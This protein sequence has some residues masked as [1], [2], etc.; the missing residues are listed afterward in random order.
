MTRAE[1]RQRI[2]RQQRVVADALAADLTTNTA[3]EL[4]GISS[5][6]IQAWRRMPHVRE[7][8]AEARARRHSANGTAPKASTAA[9]PAGQGKGQV[10]PPD[11]AGATETGV[12]PPPAR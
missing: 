1:I 6:T 11:G 3:A 10:R 7:W 8:I 5:G 9:G 2:A 4:V 12:A